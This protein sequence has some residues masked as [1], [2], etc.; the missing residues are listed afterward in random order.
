MKT[1]KSIDQFAADLRSETRRSVYESTKSTQEKRGAMLQA[2]F[3][4][5]DHLRRLAGEIKQ[6]VIENL[7]TYLP[8]VE[9][10]L[11][12]HGAQVHWATNAEAANHA[13][14]SIMRARNATKL[15]KAKT[16]VSEEIGLEP[17]LHQ[18]G[19]ECLET[20]LG[21]F[22]VQIDHDRPSHIVRP[23]IHKNRREVAESF[24]KHG[25]GAY[26]DDPG[27]I[28]QRARAFMRQKYLAADVGMTGAN[29]VVAESGRLVVV[30][31][32]GNSRFCLAATKCHIALATSASSSTSSPV[33]PP[34]SSSRFTPS[35]SA[36]PRRPLRPTDRRRCT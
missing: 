4:E 5:P 25:L 3:P 8:A 12:A 11:Q 18:N 29:F 22:I 20:D 27:V 28:T 17:F 13:V 9:A 15:V 7:D 34:P 23:I 6:H 26:N 2:H 14:L 24:E 1:H 30:T 31:N 10:Q 16:M 36:A 21:E 32:E 19:I 35:S 33:P